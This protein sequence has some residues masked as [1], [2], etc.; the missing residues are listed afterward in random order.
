MFSKV[1]DENDSWMLVG[2]VVLPGSQRVA[3]QVSKSFV[4]GPA[5]IK[6]LV[7]DERNCP[8]CFDQRQCGIGIVKIGFT[9]CD[10]DMPQKIS[11]A[12]CT[13]PLLCTLRFPAETLK[14]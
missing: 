6:G 2:H 5:W 3:R 7:C 12:W 4:L 8:S 14:S 1:E 9:V 10:N 13:V 11:T